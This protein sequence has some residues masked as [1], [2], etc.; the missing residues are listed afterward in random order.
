[1][2]REAFLSRGGFDLALGPAT[3]AYSAEDLDAFLTVILDGKTIVY[4]PRAIVRHEHRRDFSDLYW[5][6]FTYSAGSSALLTKWAR[7]RR[8]VAADFGGHMPRMMHSHT[9][10]SI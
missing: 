6:V 1:F 3:P 4:E 7:T 8:S 2:R 10:C 9:A 5:Q